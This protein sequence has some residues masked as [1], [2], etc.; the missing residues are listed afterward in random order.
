MGQPM[1][2]F[3]LVL[4]Q[5]I[6]AGREIAETNLVEIISDSGEVICTS[7][8]EIVQGGNGQATTA[9]AVTGA[10]GAGGTATTTGMAL[11]TMDIGV[12]GAA[13]AP[14]LGILAG[15]GLYSLAP[16]FWTNV[17]NA[18]FEA[19]KTVGGK[20]IAFF[21]GDN[22]FYD[23]ETIEIFKNALVDT[24]IFNVESKRATDFDPIT[25]YTPFY[26]YTEPIPFYTSI[27]CAFKTIDEVFPYDQTD[28]NYS[29][30]CTGDCKVFLVKIPW[31]YEPWGDFNEYY[32]F[33]CGTNGGYFEHVYGTLSNGSETDETTFTDITTLSE[34]VVNG[35]TYYASLYGNFGSDYGMIGYWPYSTELL[36]GHQEDYESSEVESDLLNYIFN[37]NDVI[38][39]DGGGALQPNATYPSSGEE[40]PLTYPNWLPWEYPSTAPAES[41]TVYPV[42]YPETEPDP[43]PE[44]DPAQ[45]PVPESVPDTYPH[46]IP[47]LPVPYPTP[48]PTPEPTPTPDPDP[49]PEPDPIPVPIVPD[50]TPDPVDPNPDPDPSIPIVD[51]TIPSTVGSTKLFTVYNPDETALNGL[52]AYLWDSNL[53]EILKKIWQNPLDGIISLIQVYCTPTVGSS[54][55]IILG[56]LDSEVSAPVVT[57]QF[58]TIDCGSININEDKHNATDY[59]PYTSL[60]LYLP[61]IGFVELDVNEFM[62][63]AMSVSYKVDVYTGTCIATVKAT[64]NP[65]TPNGAPVYEFSGNCSQQIPLTS[66]DAT[67]VLTAL[68]GAVGAGLAIA[69]GGGIG[70]VAGVSMLGNSMTHEMF[71]VSRSGNLSAN[72]GIMGYKKPIALISRRHCYDANNYNALYGFPSN[73]TVKL[74]NHVG[75]FTRVK[76][77][78][79][80]T[81]ATQP[82]HD[83]IMELLK[84][85][86]IL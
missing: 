70:V 41:P 18:L 45:N 29:W 44:Q 8:Y 43:Y 12:A 62:N 81:S 31:Y 42:K 79:L 48:S 53:M 57:S 66:G 19:G 30:R 83:E 39:V 58:V 32:I 11:L 6:I 38:D 59:S 28:L 78:F 26:E 69:S 46:I 73:A 60:S 22:L 16:E 77:G 2:D 20:V 54:Q 21:N 74:G 51:P 76:S 33:V 37:N 1:I 52:G 5:M 36:I 63:G 4:K 27:A 13:I 80:K 25:P 7:T 17:S 50:P 75:N 67:G 56:Y 23:E 85:G 3:S 68:T 61:F 9:C 65:D 86:V 55:H 71:H 14:C 10:V 82:E 64:R 34:Y 15:V 24:G 84:Q 47:D 35:N 40:F 49:Q 72:A